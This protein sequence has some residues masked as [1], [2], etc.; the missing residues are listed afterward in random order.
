MFRTSLLNPKVSITTA[1]DDILK[2]IFFVFQRKFDMI[3]RVNPLLEDSHE[4]SSLIFI[5]R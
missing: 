4:T 5:K 2:Y 1:A 3:F